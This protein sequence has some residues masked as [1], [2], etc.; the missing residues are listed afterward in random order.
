MEDVDLFTKHDLKLLHK[1]GEASLARKGQHMPALKIFN[2]HGPGLWLISELDPSEPDHLYALFETYNR[3]PCLGWI[4]RE[5]LED[6]RVQYSNHY[7]PLQSDRTFEPKATIDIY[8]RAARATG[9]ITED[10]E[11]L[12][13][14]TEKA[15]HEPSPWH[16]PK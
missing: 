11:H 15:T 8:A 2:P 12:D 6:C 4:S 9:R 13:K 5:H 16:G 1:N 10:P 7:V 14:A 3:K